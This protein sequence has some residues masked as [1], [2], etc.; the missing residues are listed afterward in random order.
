MYQTD[1]EKN[2]FTYQMDNKKFGEFI[3]QL[4]KEKRLTQK[5]LAG[6]L[7]ISDKAVSKWERG[8]SMP[9]VSMLIPMAEILGVTVTELLRGE[10]L[11]AESALNRDEVEKLVTR[12]M[13]M[14]LREE[15]ARRKLRKRWTGIYGATLCIVVI[16]LFVF[17]FLALPGMIWRTVWCLIRN[18]I[19][20]RL[21]LHFARETLPAY[22]DENKINFVS[23]GLS[24][25]YDRAAF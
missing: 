20:W 23:D 24:N 18:V 1:R 4:R 11:E 5:E 25:Q 8:L 2:G 15:K 22:Y 16:E 19:V 3:A 9:N 10:R 21:V 12:S 13:D 7:F 6:R 17:G 14:S